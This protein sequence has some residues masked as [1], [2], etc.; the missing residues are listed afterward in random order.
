MNRKRPRGFYCTREK[1][2]AIGAR[3]AAGNSDRAEEAGAGPEPSG[4]G[5]LF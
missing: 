4:Q 3:A 1:R 5:A 2:A